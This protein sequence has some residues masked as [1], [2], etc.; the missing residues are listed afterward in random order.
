MDERRRNIL[1]AFAV[2]LL[3]V[4]PLVSYLVAAIIGG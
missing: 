4:L 1:I 3:V 2:L